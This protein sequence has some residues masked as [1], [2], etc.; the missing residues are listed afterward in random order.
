MKIIC[1][2][3]NNKAI[4]IKLCLKFTIYARCFSN[5]LD[6]ISI[7]SEIQ[8]TRL[9]EGNKSP[10][11]MWSSNHSSGF[12]SQRNWLFLSRTHVSLNE[13]MELLARDI[14]CHLNNP[15]QTSRSYIEKSVFNKYVNI[16]WNRLCSRLSCLCHHKLFELS[17]LQNWKEIHLQGM[18]FKKLASGWIWKKRFNVS[19][20]RPKVLKLHWP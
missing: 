18:P 13:P 20:R 17:R 16:I 7:K 15:L 9:F 2:P 11:C 19:K 14:L 12:P 5:W 8:F 6:Y 3:K 10:F 1:P 4:T